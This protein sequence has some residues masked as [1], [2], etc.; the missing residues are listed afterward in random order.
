MKKSNDKHI[1]DLHLESVDCGECPRDSCSWRWSR[2][3]SQTWISST[4]A[5]VL[6]GNVGSYTPVKK[7]HKLNV[8][9]G[10]QVKV[11]NIMCS[12]QHRNECWVTTEQLLTTVA[13]S[14]S[15][16]HSQYIWFAPVR[17]EALKWC[18]SPASYW[19]QWENK[20]LHEDKELNNWDLGSIQSQTSSSHAN[21]YLFFVQLLKLK[22]HY[23]TRVFAVR[24]QQRNWQMP[25][26]LTVGNF[27]LTVWTCSCMYQPSMEDLQKRQHC[28]FTFIFPF[29]LPPLTNM[30]LYLWSCTT[31]QS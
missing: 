27:R 25:K 15:S 21:L 26:G 18:L 10:T 22:G 30:L 28:I 20:K 31:S 16:Q 3:Y 13:S 4:A 1:F 7:D 23:H 17:T 12:V 8:L 11:A 2:C 14:L 9:T 29:I 6:Q 5:S 19:N 24:I